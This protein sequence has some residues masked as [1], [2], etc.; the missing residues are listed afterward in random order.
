MIWRYRLG[1][2]IVIQLR[3]TIAETGWL[4][5]EKGV[6][7]DIGQTQGWTGFTNGLKAYL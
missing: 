2:S 6:K 3:L 7:Q 4:M 1:L 5:D